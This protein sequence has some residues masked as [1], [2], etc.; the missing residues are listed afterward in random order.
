MLDARRAIYDA[1]QAMAGARIAA[2]L[3]GYENG[4][5]LWRKVIDS[6]PALADDSDFGYDVVEAVGRYRRARGQDEKAD[7]PQPFILQDVLNKHEKR[8]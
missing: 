6:H 5:A 7:L 4:F 8:R 3:A 1:D 2:A